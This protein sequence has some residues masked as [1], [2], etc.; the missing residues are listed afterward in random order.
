MQ[1]R[2]SIIHSLLTEPA[3]NILSIIVC[4]AM[5]SKNETESFEV[6]EGRTLVDGECGPHKT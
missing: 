2:F 1:A 5:S 3:R 4:F 6:D